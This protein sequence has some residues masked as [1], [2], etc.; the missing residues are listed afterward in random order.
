MAEP[1]KAT[2]TV[3]PYN[4]GFFWFSRLPMPID[5]SILNE[6]EHLRDL[7]GAERAALA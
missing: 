5:T 4:D 2:L 7:G 1:T 3:T 6:I